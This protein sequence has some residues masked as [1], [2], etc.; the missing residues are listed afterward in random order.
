MNEQTPFEGFTLATWRVEPLQGQIV[1]PDGKAVHIAPKAMDVLVCLASRPGEVVERSTIFEEVWGKLAWSDEALTH[2]VSEIRHAFD[3]KPGKP[4][5]L[6]TIP[7]RGYRLV[8][9]VNGD[10]NSDSSGVKAQPID[11]DAGFLTRQF[12]DLRKRKVFQ[13]VLGYPV[14]AWL[15]VQIV[16]VIWQYLLEP[17]GTPGWIAPTF[18]VLVAL[19]YPVAIFLAWAVDLT[20]E[21]VKFTTG[22]RGKPP[23]AGLTILGVGSVSI[24]LLALFLYFNTQI[25]MRAPTQG[26]PD[27]VRTMSPLQKSIAV[28]RFVNLSNNPDLQHISDGLTEELIHELT[29][30]SALKVAARTTV[31]AISGSAMQAPGNRKTARRGE[32]SRRQHTR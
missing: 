13:I 27:V 31:W 29:N 24:T 21:G 23:I 7:K 30:L 18:V 3:D 1:S 25:N 26:K 22:E 2:C 15:L 9:P 10:V 4:G 5:I 16:D 14:F 20:P 19:G 32:S 8:A 17:L 6:Q 28:L 11:P 12:Q